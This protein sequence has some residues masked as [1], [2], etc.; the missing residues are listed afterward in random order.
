MSTS[1]YEIIASSPEHTIF[2]DLIRKYHLVRKLKSSK[3]NLIVFAPT[4][5]AFQKIEVPKSP[6]KVKQILL[7]HLERNTHKHQQQI[8]HRSKIVAK[9]GTVVVVQKVIV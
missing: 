9:N 4:D 7:K 2:R 1:I 5:K 8:L 3:T 6:A